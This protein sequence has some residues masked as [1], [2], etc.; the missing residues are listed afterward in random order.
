MDQWKLPQYLLHSG[1]IN[2]LSDNGGVW[3]SI[4]QNT[5]REVI[6]VWGH[7]PGFNSRTRHVS[8]GVVRV[9]E[10]IDQ[11]YTLIKPWLTTDS[12]V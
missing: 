12:P 11:G 7:A 6:K 5:I 8:A 4:C 1:R 3:L 9:L 2:G 10:L